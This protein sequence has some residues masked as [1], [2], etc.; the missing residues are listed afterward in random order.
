MS[1]VVA[2]STVAL[3]AAVLLYRWRRSPWRL[4]AVIAGTALALAVAFLLTGDSVSYLFERAAAIFGG[5]VI[6][7]VFSVLVVCV[8]LPRLQLRANRLAAVLLCGGLATMFAAVGLM[9]WRIADDGLQLPGV[10]TV[11]TAQE[12][13]AWRNAQPHQRIYGALV[14]ARLTRDA[15]GEGAA[16][17]PAAPVSSESDRILLARIDCGRSGSGLASSAQT[18]LPSAFVVELADGSRAWVQGIDSVRQA[19]NWPRGEGRINECALYS[20]DPV[21]IWGDPGKARRLGGDAELPAVNAVRVLGYGD[22]EAFRGGFV[23]A[24][25]RT[26]RATLALGVFNAVLAVWMCVIGWRQYRRLG[27]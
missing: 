4:I 27:T 13:L 16:S 15:G 12:I 11:A 24:A 1:L 26:G 22:A 7:S 5:T 9:L 25:Q 19:W 17:E 6:A 23:P 14:Q 21:V 8:V 20:G 10:P 18:W 3:A 2:W